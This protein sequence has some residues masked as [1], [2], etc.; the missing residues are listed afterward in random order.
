MYNEILNHTEHREYPM[1]DGP[2]GMTQRWDYLLFMHLPV[3]NNIL[4]PY[5]P[6]GLV[7]DTFEGSAWISILP[8]KIN[9]MH[10]RD[11]PPIPFVHSLL[12]LN[13]R[14]YV[15]RDG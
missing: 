5:I 9:N 1:P 11:L 15:K 6:K 12:E 13:V 2:W 8:F 3:S 14:T 4:A 10:F 7:L